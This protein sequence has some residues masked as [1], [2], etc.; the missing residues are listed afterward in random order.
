M[1]A[2][3]P[4]LFI[5]ADAAATKLKISRASLYAYVSRGLVQTR[6]D[7]DDPRRRLYSAA[8]ISRLAENKRRGRKP[9]TVAAA[10][11]HWGGLPALES[12]ITLIEGGQLYYRGV[13]AADL[14]A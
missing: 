9:A 12:S 1:R 4:A 6:P 5:D 11:L 13:N 10:A 8:D 2:F 7:A 3:M 14:A